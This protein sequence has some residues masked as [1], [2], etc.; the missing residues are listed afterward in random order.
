MKRRS[1]LAGS[2]AA[3]LG[4]AACRRGE[5][6]PVLS[7]L[8]PFSLTSQDGATFGTRELAGTAY[9][10]SFMFT[11][12]PSV[13]PRMMGRVKALQDRLAGD[14]SRARLVSFS[15]DP[16]HDSPEVL[17][18][19]AQRFGA[20]PARW[21]FLT[22]PIDSIRATSVD[23][24]KLALDGKLDPAADHFGLIHGSYLVLVDG[25]AQIRG[26]YRTSDDLLDQLVT[27]L[28]RI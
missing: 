27:D 13:C 23:G 26:Y 18:A 6:L 28:R 14:R 17:R 22:G 7:A 5:P 15:V 19:Y 25:S 12:C 4:A 1:W 3:A 8:P 2:T 16:E 20:D 10:A 21:T 24:F 11:R 9:V